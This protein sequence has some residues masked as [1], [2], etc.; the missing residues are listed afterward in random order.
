VTGQP[1]GVD[2]PSG[3]LSRKGTT[4]FSAARAGVLASTADAHNP[5]Q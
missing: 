5:A 3:A 2:T 4:I 1:A